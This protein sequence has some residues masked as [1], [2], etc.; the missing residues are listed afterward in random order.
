MAAGLPIVA[1]NVGGTAEALAD[2]A[3][4]VL[5]PPRD[6][7]ELARALADLLGAPERASHLAAAARRRVE[8]RYSLRRMVRE[9]ESL[10]ARLL[11]AV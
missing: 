7:A 11:A 10:Y 3:C 1:T 8:E 6:P 2:G 5:V 4:G 9:T